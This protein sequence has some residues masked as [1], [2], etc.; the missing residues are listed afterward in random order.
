MGSEEKESHPI[1][2]KS[3][4]NLR[5]CFQ[6]RWGG[7]WVFGLVFLVVSFLLRFAFHLRVWKDVGFHPT[8]WTHLYAL[9]LLFDGVTWIYIVTPVV[10]FL[11]VLPDK[12]YNSRLNRKISQTL[13]FITLFLMFLDV[14]SEWLFW[15][16]FDARFN[17]IAVDYLVYTQEVLGNIWQSYP[18]VWIL[19][20]IFV[21]SCLIF[22]LTR[23]WY[24]KRFRQT[25]LSPSDL[26]WACFS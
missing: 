11:I 13:Y 3:M 24:Q 15:D 9:G 12:F 22:Y 6:N 18:V 16:E 8:E 14:A 2:C 17:F 1:S 21:F 10:L 4:G 19:A 26:K 5:H 7:L 23:P 25:A 20:G